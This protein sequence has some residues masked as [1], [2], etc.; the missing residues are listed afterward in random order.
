MTRQTE[1]IVHRRGE[2][3]TDII[4]TCKDQADFFNFS[5]RS[6]AGGPP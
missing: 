1:R 5:K 3:D 2:V 6:V 4:I